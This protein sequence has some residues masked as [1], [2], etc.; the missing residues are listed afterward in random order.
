[1]YRYIGLTPVQNQQVWEFV[2]DVFVA[3]AETQLSI[4]A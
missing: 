3:A 1:M 2:V 4:S